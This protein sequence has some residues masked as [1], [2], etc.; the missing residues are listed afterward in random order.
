[1][2][3]GVVESCALEEVADQRRCLVGVLHNDPV[4]VGNVEEGVG[5]TSQL[6]LLHRPTVRRSDGVDNRETAG[7]GGGAGVDILGSHYFYSQR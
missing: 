1:M 3:V 2:K 7:P 6:C 4:Q 5:Q